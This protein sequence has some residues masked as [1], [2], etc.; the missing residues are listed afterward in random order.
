[1]G[2]LVITDP[3]H[4]YCHP[5]P[6]QPGHLPL[7]GRA[8]LLGGPFCCLFFLLYGNYQNLLL[9]LFSILVLLLIVC[10][11]VESNS[12]PGSDKRV[13][14]LYSNIRGVHA[15]L[16]ELAVAG[17]DYDVLVSA[18]SKV[19]DHRH[20]SEIRIPGIGCPQRLW[21]STPGAQSMALYVRE[22]F[23]SFC[24]SKLKLECSWHES[25]VLYLQ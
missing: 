25:C 7:P 23:H 21:N 4:H 22:G 13:R 6:G 15:N 17:S 19:S 5:G 16:D 9:P 2:G 10:G 24:Q 20:L 18:E 3:Y 8:A 14:V 12:A 11:D 1:M